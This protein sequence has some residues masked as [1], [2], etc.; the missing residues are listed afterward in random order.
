[1]LGVV[2]QRE[3]H[4]HW[5]GKGEK[6]VANLIHDKSAYGRDSRAKVDEDALAGSMAI[7]G[8]GVSATR[9]QGWEHYR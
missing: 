7:G 2:E 5:Q 8:I 6:R 1:M 3:H 4:G 9:L